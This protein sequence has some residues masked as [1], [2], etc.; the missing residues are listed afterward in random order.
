[1]PEKELDSEPRPEPHS[2]EA[3]AQRFLRDGQPIAIAKGQT[4]K[5]SLTLELVINRS[6]PRKELQP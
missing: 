1:M 2:F 3:S 6:T 5:A 4:K